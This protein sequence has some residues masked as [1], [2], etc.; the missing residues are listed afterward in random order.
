MVH[1]DTHV[2]IWL[3]QGRRDALPAGLRR[4]LGRMRPLVSPI[5]RV[6]LAMLQEIGRLLVS[7]SEVLDGLERQ[8][9][10]G[11]AEAAYDRVAGIAA[12]LSW[13]RD[14]FDRLI[15]AHALADDLPLITKDETLLANCAVARWD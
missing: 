6:E 8:I 12:G 5:V 13:T 2:V 1:L 14:P 15:A 11:H 4:T 7:P 3:Y 9:D 10:L